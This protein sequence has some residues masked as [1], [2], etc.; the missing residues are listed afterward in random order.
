MW[1]PHP[2]S[3]VP[4]RS[5][6]P[7][8]MDVVPPLI[9]APCSHDGCGIPD[10]STLAQ[11]P[12]HRRS[13]DRLACF[14]SQTPRSQ[15]REVALLDHLP[16]VVTMMEELPLVIAMAA[17]PEVSTPAAL[18]DKFALA[19]LQLHWVFCRRLLHCAGSS[20]E[21]FYCSGCSGPW[22]FVVPG[23]GALGAR[24]APVVLCVSGITPQSS[25]PMM[26][27]NT[28]SSC[29]VSTDCFWTS[30]SVVTPQSFWASVPAV[31][32]HKVSG[33]LCPWSR[34]SQSKIYRC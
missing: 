23:G 27:P 13:L 8:L 31:V 18:P 30:V 7:H 29:S 4:F 28:H 12:S 6:V 19:A 32:T 26:V 17:L 15:A 10:L 5:V 1:Y 25:V 14:V 33:P 20:A 9:K 21:V 24:L 2:S 34:V 16:V 11:C 3:S 22:P